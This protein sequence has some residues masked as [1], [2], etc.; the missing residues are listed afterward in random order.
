MKNTTRILPITSAL[1]FALT[2]ALTLPALA[3]DAHHGHGGDKIHMS[4][5]EGHHFSYELID[6]REKMKDMKNMPEMK[7]THHLMMHIKDAAG[8]KVDKAKV[9]YMIQNPDG[10]TRKKMAMGMA[11]GFGADVNL[12]EK[13]VYKIK[14]KVV[15]GEKKLMDAFEYE[16]K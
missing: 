3:M 1:T 15:A 2:L 13:G 14:T 6:M 5:V 7:D 8:Q 16:V 10:S 9:G 4:M 11:G 12:G